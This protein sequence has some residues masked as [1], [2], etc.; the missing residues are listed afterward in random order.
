M[1]SCAV[2]PRSQVLFV[3]V[4]VTCEAN[5]TSCLVVLTYHFICTCDRMRRSVRQCV[6]TVAGRILRCRS[7]PTSWCP[8]CIIK[9]CKGGGLLTQ[10]TVLT[11]HCRTIPA[12]SRARTAS[13]CRWSIM[14]GRWFDFAL[15]H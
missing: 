2:Q 1:R 7:W 4:T 8:A 11:A 13:A 10:A 9:K 6:L 5:I 12:S 15:T 14:T 3:E